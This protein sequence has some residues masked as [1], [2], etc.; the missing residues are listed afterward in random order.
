MLLSK[1]KANLNN[2]PITQTVYIRDLLDQFQVSRSCCLSEK[3]QNKDNKFVQQTNID[4]VYVITMENTPIR[5]RYITYMMNLFEINA[6]II[7]S[8]RVNKRDHTN[9]ISSNETYLSPGE[10]GCLLSHLWCLKDALSNNYK[11]FLILEDDVVFH[12]QWIQKLSDILINRQFNIL[13]LGATDFNF[14]DTNSS[15]VYDGIYYPDLFASFSNEKRILGAHAILYSDIGAQA[16]YRDKLD[17][18]S[19][20]DS[21]LFERF[22]LFPTSSAICSPNLCMCEQSTSIIGHEIAY[23]ETD[24]EKKYMENCVKSD[25]TYNDYHFIRL[26]PIEKSIVSINSTD[27]ISYW[28]ILFES[29]GNSFDQTCN[30]I[31]SIDTNTFTAEVVEQIRGSQYIQIQKEKEKINSQIKNSN[32]LTNLKID[33]KIILTNSASNVLNISS[34][35]PIPEKAQFRNVCMSWLPFFQHYNIPTIQVGLPKETV[36]IEYRILPHI[37][38]IIKNMIIKLGRGWSHTIVCGK[39]NESFIRNIVSTSNIKIIVTDNECTCVDEYSLLLGS[40]Y[41]WNLLSGDKILIYQEDSWLFHYS[42]ATMERCL[43][44]DYVGAPFSEVH[45]DTPN[46]VGNGGFSLR[47]RKIMLDVI[48]NYPIAQFNSLTNF[49]K[50]YMVANKLTIPPEDIYFSVNMQNMGIGNVSP[51]YIAGAFSTESVYNAYSMGGHKFW[52]SDR[53]WEKRLSNS[54]ESFFALNDYVPQSNIDSFVNTHNNTHANY[55]DVDLNFFK[56]AYKNYSDIT[57]AS[58]MNLYEDSCMTKYI[59]HPK[60]LI[61]MYGDDLHILQDNDNSLW[62][63]NGNDIAYQSL[64]SF[65]E[66]IHA[67]SYN[68]IRDTTMKHVFSSETN[69]IELT[70]KKLLAIGF[71]GEQSRGEVLISCLSEYGKQEHCTIAFCILQKLSKTIIPFITQLRTQGFFPRLKIYE[72]SEFGNDIVPS[73]LMYHKL[74]ENGDQFEYVLKLHTKSDNDLF[75]DSIMYLLDKSLDSILSD[76]KYNCECIGHPSY[77]KRIDEDKYNRYLHET[78]QMILHP[79]YYF[80]EGSMFCTSGEQFSN[81]LQFVIDNYKYILFSN[82]YDTNRTNFRASY[83]HFLER[84][85]GAHTPIYGNGDTMMID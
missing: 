67:M 27:S 5:N 30:I 57:Y 25:F 76:K 53:M 85:F 69:D 70:Y 4:H 50:D 74:I 7:I 18:P 19:A 29:I 52:L 31:K 36:L 34:I 26:H 42:Q 37:Q 59:Y 60:Q 72:C 81:V 17:H 71:I 11:K 9:Y 80:V 49:T 1:L 10:L 82:M 38:T 78:F 14:T 55:I 47:T 8:S 73:M 2:R 75:R 33:S 41:F 66:G 46:L 22:K 83:V 39:S 45:N 28:E 58:F 32:E 12:K 21:N 68:N 15:N 63:K 3:D 24:Y 35:S 54:I 48:K 51:P 65:V 23:P 44:Y 6:E 56:R 43:Y 79:K 84:L 20:I 16:M 13:L 64:H 61:N 62:I 40:E 77:Y